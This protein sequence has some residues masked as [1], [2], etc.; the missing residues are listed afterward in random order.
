MRCTVLVVLAAVLQGC[1]ARSD[2]PRSASGSDSA[3]V[4]ELAPATAAKKGTTPAPPTTGQA[5]SSDITAFDA[6]SSVSGT[7]PP[8]QPPVDTALAEGKSDFRCGIKGA[9]I[10]TSLGIGNLQVGRTIAVVK[11]TCRVRR[12][13]PELNQAIDRVVTVVIDNQPIRVTVANGL[14]WRIVFDSPRFAT[15]SGLRIGTSLAQ[16]TD[17]RG[18]HLSEGEDGLYVTLDAYCG[19]MFR[20]SIPSRETPGKPWTVANVVKRYGRASVDRIVVTRCE[21]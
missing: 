17:R 19:L 16:L 8:A 15:R 6:S 1:T 13:A 3:V 10:L 21:G 9:P 20:L 5:Q 12:D 11:Q 18:V 4:T 14:V 2:A 7:T